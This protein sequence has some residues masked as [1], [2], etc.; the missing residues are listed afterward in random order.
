[1]S[2]PP[3]FHWCASGAVPVAVA[4]KLAASPGSSVSDCGCAA[5]TGGSLTVSVAAFEV[6]APAELVTTQV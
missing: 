3:F 6:A 1:M 2:V 4:V 5:M